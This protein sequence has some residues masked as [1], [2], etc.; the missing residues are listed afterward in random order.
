[1][2]KNTYLIKENIPKIEEVREVES[3]IEIT[4]KSRQIMMI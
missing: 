1:M 2:T 3:E 4:S